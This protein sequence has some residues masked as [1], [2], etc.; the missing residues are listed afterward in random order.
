M[1]RGKGS[2]KR[3]QLRSLKAARMRREG[4]T[5]REIADAT[6]L[7]VEQVPNRVALGERLETIQPAS[8]NT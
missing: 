1:A 3:K 2:E 8:A 7:K 4:Y 6:G 5:N